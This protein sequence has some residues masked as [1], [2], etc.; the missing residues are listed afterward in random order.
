MT[1]CA[2]I[3]AGHHMQYLYPNRVFGDIMTLPNVEVE[4]LSQVLIILKAL[5][6]NPGPYIGY[7]D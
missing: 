3:P 7:P 2:L 4:S 1:G 5:G 6:S